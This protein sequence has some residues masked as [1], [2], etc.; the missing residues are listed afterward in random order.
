M[1]SSGKDRLRV[2]LAVLTVLALALS[3]PESLRA[4]WERGGLYLFSREFLADIPKRLFGPGRFRFL[5]QPTMAVVLGIAAGRADARE[6]RPPYLWSLLF[7]TADRGHLVRGALADIASLLLAGILVDSACQWLI[8]G[9]SY[10]GAALVVGPVLIAVP[11]AVTRAL[12][13]RAATARRPSSGPASGSTG[14]AP[15]RLENR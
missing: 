9:V 3:V 10:P 1:T 8:L 12:A 15:E 6:G 7:G 4:A 11:Y 2:A 13:N 14:S 5:L